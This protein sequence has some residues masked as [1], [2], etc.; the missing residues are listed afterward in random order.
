M[1]DNDNPFGGMGGQYAQN[2]SFGASEAP[3]AFP[4]T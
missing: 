2:V 1:S 3:R 4:P